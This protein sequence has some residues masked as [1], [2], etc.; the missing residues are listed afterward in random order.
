VPGHLPAHTLLQRLGSLVVLTLAYLATHVAAIKA[1]LCTL[2]F[3]LCSVFGVTL[4]SVP[5][6]LLLV[7]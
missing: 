2:S 5:H 6:G 7:L 1:V 3:E 4:A